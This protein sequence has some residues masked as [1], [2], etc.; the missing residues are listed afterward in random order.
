VF[1]DIEV[2]EGA[3]S[4]DV[5]QAQLFA[6]TSVA[7]E[8]QKVLTKGKVLKDAASVNAIKAGA[9]LMLM[10]SADAVPTGP[11]KAVV[12]SEDLTDAQ[13]GELAPELKQ[14]PGLVNLENTCYMNSVLQCMK[15]CEPL[16]EAVKEYS[17]KPAASA[18]AQHQTTKAL[19]E[20]FYQLDAAG[21]SFPPH[22][23]CNAFRSTFP[24]FAERSQRG[25][26][27]QHDAEEALTELTQ[28]IATKVKSS[29]GA[30]SSSSS[31]GNTVDELFQF[32]VEQSGVCVEAPEEAST[33]VLTK[34]RKM[35]CF[36]NEKI[37]HLHMGY[38]F[39]FCSVCCD[40]ISLLFCLC[41]RTRAINHL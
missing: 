8:R 31:G 6:L 13:R 17:R 3:D 39:L 19:G 26:F 2:E 27:M 37:N 28:L 5:L 35:Q 34:Q 21:E 29:N 11:A 20:L 22:A 10:G 40:V 30:S 9:K 33:S 18:D 36:I 41:K 16:K 15:G 25:G 23:F 12:F 7:P 32:D 14:A 38:V 24:R 1:K 4:F